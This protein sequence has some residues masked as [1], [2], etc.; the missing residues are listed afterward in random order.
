M[1]IRTIDYDEE[2]LLPPRIEDWV[3]QDHPARYLRDFVD[4]LDL[5]ALGFDT[6]YEPEGRA[7]IAA[8]TLLKVWLFGYYF[9][10]RSTRKLEAACREMMGAI[11]LCG[12]QA[13]DHTT[14]WRF[15]DRHRDAI[16]K[17]FKQ[18]VHVAARVGLV[19]LALY[20]LDGTTISAACSR[21]TGWNKKQ[22]EK[23]LEGLSGYLSQIERLIEENA[24]TQAG[25]WELE[26]RLQNAKMRREEI[27]KALV[28][29]ENQQV[30]SMHPHEPDAA[31]MNCGDGRKWAWNCQAVVDEANSIV[32][33]ADVTNEAHDARCLTTMLD[34][35]VEN[36]DGMRPD[37]CVVDS[38]YGRSEEEM[39]KA[40]QAGHSFV[41][42]RPSA[43][44]GP[45][46]RSKFEFNRE[47]LELVCPL[48]QQLR[49][50]GS[51]AYRH[52]E[53]RVERFR[54]TC[55]RTCPAAS[56]CCGKSKN[57]RKVE[58][59]PLHEVVMRQ[60]EKVGYGQRLVLMNRRLKTVE[61]YFARTKHHGGFLRFLFRGKRKV[62]QQWQ[63]L[64][65][66]HN[67]KVI[68]KARRASRA[69]L[70]CAVQATSRYCAAA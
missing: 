29:L 41:S 53:G 38:A 8:D 20:A 14:L 42:S 5:D 62:R 51:S 2:F 30:E 49:Y 23:A 35:A 64:G 1:P 40:E 13:P 45:Y 39:A 48:G 32:V 69:A 47:A 59:S 60:R 57:G 27:S 44:K 50:V 4:G 58:I 12:N 52:G 36:L 11:W 7:R 15:W 68:E 56:A 3:P 31:V 10:I 63:M 17:L 66:I 26:K 67:L 18:S 65:L 43:E 22:L 61:P 37:V 19:Q 16:G 54:C 28:E 6:S 55:W 25:S 24:N 21:R 70:R 34:Q 9:G 46:H 33:A